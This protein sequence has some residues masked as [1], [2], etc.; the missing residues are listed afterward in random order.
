MAR[1]SRPQPRAYHAA[2]FSP[3]HEQLFIWGGLD[4]KK[5]RILTSGVDI[6]HTSKELWERKKT[7]GTSPPG[8]AAG[9]Y[10]LLGESLYYFGGRKS[11]NSEIYE[12]AVYRLNL[13][14]REPEWE[15]IAAKNPGQAPKGKCGSG[16]VTCGK[17]R[18]VV[19]AGLA[20]GPE[21][22][23]DVDIFDVVKREC[24]KLSTM[25]SYIQRFAGW[26]PSAI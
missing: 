1:A 15:I 7:N 25:E 3:R 22:T 6:L 4:G 19:F 2:L 10:V 9:A 20:K 16:M 23:N 11:L 5:S 21:L 13:Q 24:Q 18:I 12:N 26:L 17:D 14:M 8:C